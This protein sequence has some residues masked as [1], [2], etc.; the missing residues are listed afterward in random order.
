[1]VV[2]SANEAHI[3]VEPLVGTGPDVVA[4]IQSM[5]GLP[6]PSIL[7]TSFPTSRSERF[8]ILCFDPIACV[9]TAGAWDEPILPSIL[10]GLAELPIVRGNSLV[11]FA[12]GWIGFVSYE[13]GLP[14]NEIISGRSVDPMIPLVRFCL[15]DSAAV[16]DH[17][18]GQWYLTAIEWG[19]SNPRHSR[20]VQARLQT[21][22]DLLNGAV[23]RPVAAPASATMLPILR[24][25]LSRDAYL[26]RV[27]RIQRYIEAGDVYQVNLTQ[28]YLTSTTF[29]PAELYLRLREATPAPYAALLAWDEV[30]VLSA[31]PEL[32]LDFRDGR[33]IT[34]PIKGTRPRG[35]APESDAAFRRELASSEKDRA[36]LNMII[37]L[38]RNDLGRICSYG[39]IRVVDSGEI[40]S[41]PTVHHRVA[42]IEGRLDIGKPWTELFLSMFPGGSVTGAPK[43]RAMQIIAELESVP[44]GVYCGAIGYV[45]IDGAVRF[46]LAIRTMTKIGRTVYAQAGGGIVADSVPQAEYEEML[47]KASGMLRALGYGLPAPVKSLREACPA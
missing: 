47:V 4:A 29:S 34:Q 36:E 40:E 41:H 21:M 32:F 28:R 19:G 33:A 20:P 22:R 42:T 16:F 25:S 12:G 2:K 38:L 13:A 23:H 37:D 15:Y 27:S 9:S 17:A 8:T 1:M 43:I 26:E 3:V 31:S 7:D 44:R 5:A 18:H 10:K 30:A 46:N 6:D 14:M 35:S 45:G 24:S 39:S 11:P